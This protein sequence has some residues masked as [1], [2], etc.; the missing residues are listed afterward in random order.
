MQLLAGSEAV[1]SK[2]GHAPAWERRSSRRSVA[3]TACTASAAC[4]RGWF[5]RLNDL[6]RRASTGR[7]P[8]SRRSSCSSLRGRQAQG[9]L[10]GA[11]AVMAHTV[12]VVPGDAGLLQA[13][14]EGA[15]GEAASFQDL[16]MKRLAQRMGA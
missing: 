13:A 4:A 1:G 5:F 11:R 6:S 16:G 12:A 8:L 2:P 3:W 14:M 10:S 15:V 7:M 9:G